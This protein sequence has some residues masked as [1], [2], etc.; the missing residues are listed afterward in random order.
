MRFTGLLIDLRLALRLVWHDWRF[1]LTLVGT[2]AIGIA[3]SG[4]IFNVVNATLLRPLPIPDEARVYRLQDYTP[5]PDGQQVRRSN[6]VPNFLAIRDETRGFSEVIGMRSVEW[7]LI[8]GGVPVP[9]GV[10]LVSAGSFDL[11]GAGAQAGR[12]PS[13]DEQRLGIDA[14]V[15]VL[16]HSLWQRQ[17]GGRLDAIGRTVRV[18]DHVVSIIGVMPPGFRFPYDVE[19]WMPEVVDPASEVSLAVFARLASGVSPQQ[20]QADLDAVAVRAEVV[21]PVAN[22]GVRFAMTPVR[23]SLVGDSS[24][25]SLALM[26]AALLLLLLASANVA[27]LL[28]ARGVRRAQEIAVR[29]ALGAERSRQVRQMLVE[30]LVF[31]ALGTIVGLAVAHPLS[32]ALVGIVPNTLRDQLGLTQTSIDVRAALFAAVTMVVVGVVAG[33]VPALKVSSADVSTTLRQQTRGGSGSHRLMRGL[34]ITEVALA[35]VLLVCAGLMVDNLQRLLAADLGL[36]AE[37]LYAFRVPLPSRYDTAEKRVQLVNQLHETVAAMPGAERAAVV[38]W[39][40]LGR[41]SFGAALESEDRPL[42]PG[43][44]GLIVNHRLVTADWLTTAGVPLLLGRHFTTAD[45][46]GAVPVAIVSRRLADRLW[47]GGEALGKRIRQTRGDAPWITVVGVAGDVRDSGEWE[48]TWYVPYA[49]H[50]GTLAGSTVHLMVR[51]SVEAGAIVNGLRQATSAIDPLLPVP[52]PAVMATLWSDAQTE[53]RMGAMVS[54]LFGI[55][56]LLLAALGTYGVLAYLVS[57]RSREFGIRQ[58]L[59]ARPRDVHAMVMR[60]GLVLAGL[61]LAIGAALSVAAV[62][63]LQ[64]VTTEVSGVPGALPWAVAGALVTAAIAASLL[65]ARRATRVAPVEVM[66]SE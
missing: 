37:R 57:A 7:S 66:R 33:L 20:A 56:G 26:A 53:Q 39:N 12:L 44:S 36:R 49:Q 58:A 17:F 62:Q 27:N 35:S 1:S 16:S 59:G 6:R 51:S 24:R 47:P 14:G 22:R 13:T 10:A 43:Q 2:L 5:G 64:S 42:A 45:V 31:A 38:S 61:G 54:A 34:V 60:D 28:L 19:A 25:T 55:S 32:S 63:A 4:A 9:V 8:D 15:L 18:E 40:P 11:L 23:E 21:R 52:E 48:E 30:S 65:P 29:A 50:A 41:G 46:A 3:A